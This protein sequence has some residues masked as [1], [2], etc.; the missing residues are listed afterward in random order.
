MK[1]LHVK[2]EDGYTV[3]LVASI[4]TEDILVRSKVDY[5]P[6]YVTDVFGKTKRVTKDITFVKLLNLLRKEFPKHQLISMG[7]PVNFDVAPTHLSR[8]EMH[9]KEESQVRACLKEIAVSDLLIR[10][11]VQPAW[12]WESP[13]QH[14]LSVVLHVAWYDTVYFLQFKDIFL[15]DLHCRYSAKFGFDPKDAKITHFRYNDTGDLEEFKTLNKFEKHADS[16]KDKVEFLRIFRDG[17]V[18]NT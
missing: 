12:T 9:F 3:T 7:T 8:V 11:R 14:G 1:Y 2:Q 18:E 4:P 16:I 15:G 10:S 6:Q 5:V 17:S 13:M